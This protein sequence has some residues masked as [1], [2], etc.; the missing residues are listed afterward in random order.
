MHIYGS[1]GKALEALPAM[2]EKGGKRAIKV[3]GI[4]Q[5]QDEVAAIEKAGA[6][7]VVKGEP[8]YPRLLG[9]LSS[10]PPVLT[11][12]GGISLGQKPCISVVGTRDCTISGKKMA[13]QIAKDL[14]D[15][16]YCVVSGLTRG[17]DAAAHEGALQSQG[18]GTIGVIGTGIDQVYP[19][20]SDKLHD[21]IARRGLILS[22]FP[23]GMGPDRSTFPRRNRTVSGLSLGVV[24]VEAD[25]ESGSMITARFAKDQG[26]Q[27]WAVP[28]FPLD[29]KAGGPNELLQQGAK[30]VTSAADII[31]LAKDLEKIMV[32]EPVFPI[33]GQKPVALPDEEEMKEL[34]KKVMALLSKT[35]VTVEE[36]ITETDAPLTMVLIALTELELAG[37]ITRKDGNL[38]CLNYDDKED[39]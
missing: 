2:A 13:F 19:Q 8:E 36:I 30:I 21:E 14:C 1:A 12:K 28:G 33:F 17:I 11:Y 6:K 9:L 7:F 10:A 3:C 15:G 32:K 22:E 5:A 18:G 26:R 24:V 39:L 16:G 29:A 38:I 27:V 35:W 4:Q 20:S 37:K 34:R 31:K 25:V 23:Y